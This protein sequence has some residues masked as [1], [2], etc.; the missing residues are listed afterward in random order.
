M[1]S[2]RLIIAFFRVH[3]TIWLFSV[4]SSLEW[5][6]GHLQEARSA[7]QGLKPS[8]DGREESSD[9]DDLGMR[10]GDVPDDKTAADALPEPKRLLE[11]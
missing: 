8:P 4:N 9:L 1:F 5:C 3:K 10:P 7:A 2:K 11:T 6:S